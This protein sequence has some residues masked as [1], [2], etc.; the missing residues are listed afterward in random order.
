MARL[1][2]KPPAHGT[3]LPA[4]QLNDIYGKVVKHTD[5]NKKDVTVIM[6]ICAHCPY[7]KAVEERLINLGRE[8]KDKVS[9]VAIC[10]NDASNYPEDSPKNLKARAE[11]MGYPFPYLIDESQDVARAFEAVCTPDIFVYDKNR[12]LAYH[13]RIDDNWKKAEDVTKEELKEAI[14]ALLKGETPSKT[15]QPAIGCSIKWKK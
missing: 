14:E 13:G 11:K 7:V 3:P 5:I 2:S 10:S 6:F 1:E 4:F 15:Q 9:F 8:F 12:K